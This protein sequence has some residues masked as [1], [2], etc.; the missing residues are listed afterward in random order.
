MLSPFGVEHPGVTFSKKDKER[1]EHYGR[2]AGT[3]GATGGAA[4]GLAIGSGTVSRMERKGKDPMHFTNPRWE[5]D[6]KLSPGAKARILAGHSAAHKWQSKTAGSL[7]AGSLALA[8]GYKLKQKKELAKRDKRG[9]ASDV[10]LGTGTAAAGATALGGGAAFG[11]QIGGQAHLAGQEARSSHHTLAG[12]KLGAWDLDPAERKFHLTHRRA[13]LKVAGVKGAGA[14][15]AGTAAATGGAA[16]YSLGRRGGQK[17]RRNPK[18]I[19]KKLKLATQAAE[20]GPKVAEKTAA[21]GDKMADK[22]DLA[23]VRVMGSSAKMRRR[24]REAGPVK[25]AAQRAVGRAG[26]HAAR[27]ANRASYY[28]NY[29][30]GGTALGGTSAGLAGAGAARGFSENRRKKS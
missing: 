20:L 29:L 22:L 8:G 9:R 2:M 12:E 1:A 25:G 6:K 14:L 3:L 17:A 4:G 11:H 5:G 26:G 24:G 23:S 7:A 18:K 27:V 13:N 19:E 15:A 10:A 28:P 16:L 21:M 30:A